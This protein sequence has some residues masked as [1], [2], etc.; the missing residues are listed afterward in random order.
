MMTLQPKS[1]PEEA[2]VKVSV[3]EV[4]RAAQMLYSM[5]FGEGANLA[6]AGQKLAHEYMIAG[7]E[8]LTQ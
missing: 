5:D 3:E 8:F 4:A 7:H 1:T 6:H 2:A